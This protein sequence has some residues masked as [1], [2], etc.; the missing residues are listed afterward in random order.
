VDIEANDDIHKSGCYYRVIDFNFS[1]DG[2]FVCSAC[3]TNILD[4]S[5]RQGR[6]YT[7]VVLKSSKAV[8]VFN[9]FRLL[10]QLKGS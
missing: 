8:T 9:G 2:S 1:V 10:E 7:R 6:L 3:Y 4:Y 5:Q